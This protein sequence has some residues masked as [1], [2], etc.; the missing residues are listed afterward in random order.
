ML[1]TIWQLASPRV[2][3]ET[4]RERGSLPNVKPEVTYDVISEVTFL[5]LCHALLMAQASLGTV[6]GGY[7]RGVHSSR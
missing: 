1:F 7:T 6:N 4:Q 2:R 5:H 3:E